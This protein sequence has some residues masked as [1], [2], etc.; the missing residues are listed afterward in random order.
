[1]TKSWSRA[2]AFVSG[3][4]AAAVFASRLANVLERDT[5]LD[6]GGI[7]LAASGACETAAAYVPLLSRPHL[8]AAWAG[9]LITAFVVGGVAYAIVA[10]VLRSESARD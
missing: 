2:A 9:L 8:Y 4:V 10:R 3:V 1:M 6:A 5:C 7:Y